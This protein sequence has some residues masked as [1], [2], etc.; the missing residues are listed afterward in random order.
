MFTPRSA[1]TQITL[2]TFLIAVCL[3]Q[4]LVLSQYPLRIDE[5]CSRSPYHMF[6][7]KKMQMSMSSWRLRREPLN[8]PQE[9]HIDVKRAK[10]PL[11][12]CPLCLG[13]EL[14]K[15]NVCRGTGEIP[16]TG[17]GKKNKINVIKM[18]GSNWTSC[19][20]RHGWRHFEIVGRR[21]RTSKDTLFE[22]SNCCGPKEERITFLVS[23]DEIKDKSE[24]RHGWVTLAEIEAGMEDRRSCNRCKSMRVIEC[25]MC[26]GMGLLRANL[27]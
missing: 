13:R 17:F 18:I 15:C 27:C 11:T 22:V 24:W 1:E 21:G 3:A 14:V 12:A 9:H 8:I 20:T 6:A 7:T 26:E 16:K 10:Q 25:P 23:L 4:A 5:G 19:R 2:L